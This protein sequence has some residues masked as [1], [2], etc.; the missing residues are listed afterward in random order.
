VSYAVGVRLGC[1]LGRASP[2]DSRRLSRRS[3]SHR[4]CEF[5]EKFVP[6]MGWRAAK[7]RLP[8]RDRTCGWRQRRAGSND[9]L[10]GTSG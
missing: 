10:D 6:S 7:V 5:R 4:G 9:H 2:G 1:A 8:I 3:R